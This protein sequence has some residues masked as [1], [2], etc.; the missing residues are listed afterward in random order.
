MCT[1]RLEL[2]VNSRFAHPHGYNTWSDN[3]SNQ[4][5]YGYYHSLTDYQADELGLAAREPSDT[6]ASGCNT[7]RSAETLNSDSSRFSGDV[8]FDEG[9]SDSFV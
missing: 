5:V 7:R 6:Q 2:I 3:D 4:E 9:R 8:G 1:N